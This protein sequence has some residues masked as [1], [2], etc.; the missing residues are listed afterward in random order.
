MQKNYF[1]LDKVSAIILTYERE[2]S[3]RWRDGI[4]AKPKTFLGIKYGMSDAIPAGWSDDDEDVRY[5]KPSSYFDNYNWY[6][7]DEING[8]VYNRARVDVKFSHQEGIGANFDSNEEAQQYVDELIAS[9]DKKFAV[10]I[11]K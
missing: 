10:I 7:A 9:S 4:P 3:Y 2:T 8:K 1:Q 6:R 5:T 11:N